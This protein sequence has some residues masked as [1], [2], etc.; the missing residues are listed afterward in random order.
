MED[1]IYSVEYNTN[2]NYNKKITFNYNNDVFYISSINDDN[3]YSNKQNI[4]WTMS[5]FY[6]FKYFA[7]KELLEVIQE[8]KILT[9]NN[10]TVKE[11]MKIL[12]Q[13]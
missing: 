5:D 3:Y 11:A 6:W 9:N 8:Q 13:P 2:Y 7:S 10:I 4:W 1:I 12:Y